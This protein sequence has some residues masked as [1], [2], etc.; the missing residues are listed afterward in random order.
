MAAWL[1]GMNWRFPRP[2]LSWAASP[3]GGCDALRDRFLGTS[4]VRASARVLTA[5]WVTAPAWPRAASVAPPS[6][7]ACFAYERIRQ[8][9]ER[10][11]ACM[12]KELCGH[13]R[14]RG[15]LIGKPAVKANRRH[16][17][18]RPLSDTTGH[19]TTLVIPVR[20]R[21]RVS[22][23]RIAA[24][25][26]FANSRAPGDRACAPARSRRKG[27]GGGLGACQRCPLILDL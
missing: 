16:G 27:C 19:R 7:E 17:E 21:K 24:Y 5:L 2:R 14:R 13:R 3:A 12:W 4:P 1:S 25:L 15:C 23:P 18:T 20:K 9:G 10:A 26:P 6:H 22:A 11:M 8:C